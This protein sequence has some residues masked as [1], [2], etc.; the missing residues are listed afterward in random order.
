MPR[1][2][3]RGAGIFDLLS[4]DPSK[5]K[6]A[7]LKQIEELKKDSENKCEEIKKKNAVKIEKLNTENV[8]LEEKINQKNAK[9]ET[10]WYSGFFSE[11]NDKAAT[12]DP[13]AVTDKN[14]SGFFSGLFS[15]SDEKKAAGPDGKAAAGPDGKAAAGPDGKAAAGP[16]VN[17]TA[18]VVNPKVEEKPV[19]N[20]M[21]GGKKRKSQ[22]RRK[23]KARKSAK[24]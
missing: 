6:E 15:G 19:G 9:P 8:A 18:N 1:R 11:E 24:K 21:F 23:P 2:Q 7:N 13:P 5:K 22:R 4:T 3:Q 12:N 20:R 10:S 17:T 14:D 16:D